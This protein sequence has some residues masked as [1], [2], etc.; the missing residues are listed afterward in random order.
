MIEIINIKEEKR[1]KIATDDI[2]EIRFYLIGGETLFID[3]ISQPKG[4][5]IS[6]ITYIKTDVRTVHDAY[7]SCLNESYLM[8][9]TWI[10]LQSNYVK[11]RR[12]SYYGKDYRNEGKRD[13]RIFKQ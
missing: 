10:N 13:K 4:S 2:E 5:D 12:N 7:I 1:R 6:T 3:L 8:G 9:W 11:K